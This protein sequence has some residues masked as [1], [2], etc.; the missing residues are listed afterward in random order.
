MLPAKTVRGKKPKPR[1][2]PG[3]PVECGYKPPPVERLSVNIEERMQR[4]E[5][6]AERRA[7]QQDKVGTRK[8]VPLWQAGTSST[9]DACDAPTSKSERRRSG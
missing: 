1:G 2:T 6:K 8:Y 4:A 9:S 7:A 3:L 5:E